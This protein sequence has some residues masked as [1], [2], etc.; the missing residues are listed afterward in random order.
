M[1]QFQAEGNFSCVNRFR[2]GMLQPL[3][4]ELFA[5]IDKDLGR[6]APYPVMLIAVF[7]VTPALSPPDAFA[8]SQVV[9]I[10]EEG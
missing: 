1:Y 9:L 6:C 10:L 4:L 2:P 3:I 7:E 5:Q 8:L